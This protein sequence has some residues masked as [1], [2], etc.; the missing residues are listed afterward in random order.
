[1]SV[2]NRKLFN[3]ELYQSKG[4]GI[5]TGLD[6]EDNRLNELFEQQQKILQGMRPPTQE[7]SKFEAAS[8]ALIALGAGLMSGRS[9][10]GGFGGALDILGQATAGALPLANEALAARRKAKADERAEQ[11]QLDLQAYGSATE[12]LAAEKLA[13]A[14]KLEDVA[15]FKHKGTFN[16]VFTYPTDPQADGY[17]EEKAGLKVNRIVSISAKETPTGTQYGDEII[18]S[19]EPYIDN[20]PPTAVAKNIIFNSGVKNGETAP[21][22]VFNDGKVV[23]FDPKNELADENGFVN[24]KT[25]DGNFELYTSQT[26]DKKSDF[27]TKN[28]ISKITNNIATFSETMAKGSNLLMQGQNLGENLN[29]FNRFILDT[30]GNILG[31]FSPA[32]KQAL[33]DWFEQN[34]KELTKFVADARAYAAQMIAPYTGEDSSRVSE[35]EREITNQA[36]R[37]FNGIVDAET[38]LAAIEASIALS[39]VSQHRNFLTIPDG[40]YQYAVNLPEDQGGIKG[41]NLNKEAAEYHAAKLRRLGLSENVIK[42][43]ILQMQ[44]MEILG[45]EE[46]K[47][48]TDGFNSRSTDSINKQRD[49][50]LG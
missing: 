33:F 11:F 3:N 17:V 5:T 49:D 29:T 15:V 45:L 27:L 25:Y 14:K 24:V 20:T 28:D 7:V 12:M 18:L 47:A 50:L 23:Y 35:P 38:A 34:P 42:D 41:W 16:E 43:V 40:D 2:F 48:I 31:Q 6:T 32:A 13:E 8:P 44:S 46:L 26:T 30:G 19:E 21:A 22:M 9:F 1:M 4:T 37:L 39:Y 10:Q 36:L